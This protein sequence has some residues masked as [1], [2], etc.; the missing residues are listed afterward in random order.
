MTPSIKVVVD[1]SA[2][3]SADMGERRGVRVVPLTLTFGDKTYRDGIDLLPA[4][5][6]ALLARSKQNPQTSA[7]SVSDFATCYQQLYAAGYRHVVVI[8]VTQTMSGTYSNARLAAEQG[9][10]S[11]VTVIDSGQGAGS[12]ALMAAYAAQ[13]AESGGTLDEVLKA[14]SVA[15]TTTRL[16][17]AVSTLKYLQRSGRLSAPQAVMGEAIQIKPILTFRE[18]RLAVEKRVRTMRRAIDYML[19]YLQ[20][21]TPEHILIMHAEP[22]DASRAF[23]DRIRAQWGSARIDSAPVSGIVGGHTG[24]GLL[25]VAVRWRG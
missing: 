23:A 3:I 20:S 15:Q 5:F 2:G 25:G 13:I 9:D 19:D 6:Y 1:S 24:P 11:A 18:G 8:T 12:Q 16:L 7:P 17:M 22:N 10:P 14:V 4:D 21:G